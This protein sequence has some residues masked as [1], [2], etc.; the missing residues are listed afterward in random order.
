MKKWF[1]LLFS[2]VISLF[3]AV[4]SYL[5][6]SEESPVAKT[7]IVKQ[8]FIAQEEDIR[9]EI[10][11][12]SYLAPREIVTLYVN[13]EEA[14]EQ[15]LIQEGDTIQAGDEL[16]LLE[17][18]RIDGQVDAWVAE[19][20][21]LQT[22]RERIEDTVAMLESERSDAD[23]EE[24]LNS[25]LSQLEEEL[26]LE[27][28]VKMDQRGSYAQAIA[29]AERE[30][31]SID[32]QLNMLDY[33]IDQ[34]Y[35]R[36]AIISPIS[37]V[38]ARVDRHSDRPT[39][40]IYSETADLVTYVT[41]EEWEDLMLGN[42]VLITYDEFEERGEGTLDRLDTIPAQASST[43]ELFE[44]AFDDK[45]MQ[46][47]YEV[48]VDPLGTV[49][50]QLYGKRYDIA[51]IGQEAVD[52]VVVPL[53]YIER[54]TK[55][56]GIVYVLN[57][58]GIPTK[59]AITIDFILEDEAITMSLAEGDVVLR[60]ALDLTRV[61]LPLKMMWPE[62]QAWKTFGWKNYVKYFVE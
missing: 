53:D 38:V 39:I 51:L 19:Q 14:I 13:D 17:T 3:I 56:E 45:Q 48:R 40:D 50:Q 27:F 25:S 46:N 11:K 28:N 21:A 2:L 26:N 33:Q 57:E 58:E 20:S 5:V 22:Q 15:W 30:L 9:Q 42:D 41:E 18:E 43:L 6:F 36:P 54:E 31:A 62:R 10:E 32:R 8:S 23:S 59:Q 34:S 44:K 49:E 35:V 60:E 4:N 16:V 7:K 61:A 52:S 55:N 29:E 1:I 24:S 37:G 12:P 47:L